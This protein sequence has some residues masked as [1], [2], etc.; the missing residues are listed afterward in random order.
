[1]SDRYGEYL[2]YER[3]LEIVNTTGAMSLGTSL[4]TIMSAAHAFRGPA[5]ITD[6][7]VIIG[8]EVI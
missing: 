3:F 2:G 8:V 4:D 7:I 6:D 5:P 1:M